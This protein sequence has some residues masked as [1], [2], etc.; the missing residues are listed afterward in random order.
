MSRK[1][2]TTLAE[3]VVNAAEASLAAEGYASPIDMLIEIGWLYPGAVKDWQQGRID[4]LDGVIQVNP[5]RLS[6]AM[7][8]LRSWA[9]GKG[10]IASETEYL[11]RTPQ[12]QT[13]RFS[14]RGDAALERLYRTHWISSDLS[15]K[16]RERLVE[17]ANR[18]LALVAI[19]PVNRDWKCH[20]C[21]GTRGLLV[22]EK[23]GAACLRCVGLDDL[24]HLPAGD[25][26]LTRR[27]KAKS[28][29][30]A[31]VVR[32]SPRRGRYERLGLLIEPDVLQQ[33]QSDLDAQRRQ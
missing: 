20:R 16:K 26:L 11:A 18:A 33:V 22:M 31:V 5:T 23:P 29:R 24:E 30:H 28:A 32:F 12:R 7:T 14:Q 13:L 6:E 2:Q 17:K 3:R 19:E 1:N 27:V 10:L 21:G 8:L 9:A 15:K 4:C 25:A